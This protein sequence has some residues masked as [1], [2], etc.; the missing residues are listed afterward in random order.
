MTKNTISGLTKSQIWGWIILVIIVIAAVV[1]LNTN[2]KADNVQ[3]LAKEITP[4]QASQFQKD[5]AF[6]LDVREP[7][8]WNAGHISGA[9]LIS[10]GNLPSRL[11]DVPKNKKIVVVCRSGN[12]SATGRDILL[13]AGYPRVTS[14]G[15]GMNQWV[16]AGLPVVTSP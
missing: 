10:L 4:S 3:A 14:M 1:F 6:I 5:G 15:G 13:K 7:D 16:A 9:V 12:R 8:E 2:N 11:N